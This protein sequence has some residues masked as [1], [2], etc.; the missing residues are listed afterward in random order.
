VIAVVVRGDVALAGI[1]MPAHRTLE[2]VDELALEDEG[3]RRV[4]TAG[5][6]RALVGAGLADEVVANFAALWASLGGSQSH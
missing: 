2:V 1:A 3:E 4:L 5:E 6:A